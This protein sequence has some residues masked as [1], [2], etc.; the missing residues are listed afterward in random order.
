[1]AR[2][3]P[4]APINILEKLYSSGCLG[5]YHLVL[6]HDV[7]KH[8]KRYTDLFE[9]THHNVIIVDNSVIELQNPIG[10]RKTLD[11]CAQFRGSSK[12]VVA[13]LPDC[14][15]DKEGTYRATSDALSKYSGIDTYMERM[16]IPQGKT[17]K[18]FIESAE[19]FADIEEIKWIGIARN[20]VPICGTRTHVALC[21]K[22]IYPDAKIHMLGF[23]HHLMDDLV[24]TKLANAEGIDSAVPLR[25]GS[26]NQKISIAQD[27]VASRGDWW[28]NAKFNQTVIDNVQKVRKWLLPPLK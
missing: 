2:F 1:M 13:V 18:E 7:L 12:K 8:S 19:A 26:W 25:Q 20:I 28:E 21:C 27:D 6:T 16:F 23:S 10:F 9:A 22:M 11:A 15:L 3:A 4:V 14:L 5:R 17:F 24:S